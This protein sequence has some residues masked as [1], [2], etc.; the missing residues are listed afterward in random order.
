MKVFKYLFPLFIVLMIAVSCTPAKP[1]EHHP[2][3]IV[4]LPVF[5]ETNDMNAENVAYPMV[6]RA[7]FDRGYN[8]VS[9]TVM[10]ELFNE[11]KGFHEAG[12][13]N[14]MTPEQIAEYTNADAVM[15]VTI[16]DWSTKFYGVVSTVTVTMEFKLIDPKTNM[17]IFETTE[18]AQSD[19][20]AD[21]SLGGVV[22]AI[23]HAAVQEYGPIAQQCIYN[24]AAKLERNVF[25]IKK[26][27]KEKKN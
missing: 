12:M 16:T 10:F 5:N 3:K 24:A 23:A 6:Y 17:P 8:V 22:N 2:R 20:G 4:I 14:A 18:T 7:F 11:E 15:Y 13:V 21:F 26:K 27:E 25:H 9:P 19:S 1:V